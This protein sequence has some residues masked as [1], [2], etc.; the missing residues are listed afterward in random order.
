M[1]GGRVQMYL[2]IAIFIVAAVMMTYGKMLAKN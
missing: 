1:R 2:A